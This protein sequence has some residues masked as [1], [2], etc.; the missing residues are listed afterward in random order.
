VDLIFQP[1]GLRLARRWTIASRTGPGGGPGTDEFPVILVR[2]R[3][4][5][6]WEGLGESAPSN[7]YGETVASV[8]DFLRRVDPSR[9]SFED[10]PASHAYLDSLSAADHAAKG[11]LDVA[12]TDGAAKRAGKAVHDFLGLRFTEGRH[13]TSFSIGIDTPEVIHTKVTEAVDYPVLKLKLGSDTDRENL[14]ALRAASPSKPVRVDANEAW[15]TK[16][17][18]LRE[19]TGCRPTGTSNSSSNRCQPP[20]RGRNGNGSRN[21]PR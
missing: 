17:T 7:R 14:A 16:E 20:R 12:L 11:A 21:D 19:L 9:L 10:L 15:K 2:L 13:I 3:D 1:F 6:G 4:N 18:A 8:A 5:N